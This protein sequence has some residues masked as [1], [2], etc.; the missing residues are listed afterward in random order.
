MYALAVLQKI[1]TPVIENV[2]TCC[3]AE[4]EYVENAYTC[5]FAKNEYAENAYT[6]CFAE[7]EYNSWRKSIHLLFCRK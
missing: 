4:N 3:F 2:Y 7:N 5:C 1:N 6:C